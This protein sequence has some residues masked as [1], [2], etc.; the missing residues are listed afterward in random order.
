MALPS[1]H[2]APPAVYRW[3]FDVSFPAF[4]VR[5]AAFNELSGF[6]YTC[7]P[8]EAAA[9]CTGRGD[10]LLAAMGVSHV[11][12]WRMCGLLFLETIIFRVLAFLA[13]HFMYTGQT[14]RQRLRT[15][16]A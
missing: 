2:P 10:D 12:L 13:M 8:D 4:G 16:C 9:G 6:T 1:I 15:L 3:L 5:S 7:S 11:D 14:F